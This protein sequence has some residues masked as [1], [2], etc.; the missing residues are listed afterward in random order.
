MRLEL[1]PPPPQADLPVEPLLAAGQVRDVASGAYDRQITSGGSPEL[2]V[3][4]GD[5]DGMRR[6][7]AAELA[8]VRETRSQVEWINDQLKLQADPA[9]SAVEALELVENAIPE[10]E[11]AGDDACSLAFLPSSSSPPIARPSSATS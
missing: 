11:A 5:V 9:W 2:V 1:G 6:K 10:F 8:E 3:L 7:I 4:A